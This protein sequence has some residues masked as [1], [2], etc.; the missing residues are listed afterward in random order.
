MMWRCCGRTRWTAGFHARFSATGRRYHYVILNRPIRPTY[1]RGRVSWEYRPL[2]AAA[3]Q[4][5]AQYLIGEHDFSSFR[6]AECQAKSPVREL[7]GLE[8]TRHGEFVHIRVYAN[9]FL[10][11]MVRNIAGVLMSIGAGEQQTRLGEGSAR[12]TRPHA[13]RRDRA[14]GRALSSPTSSTPSSSKSSG[15]HGI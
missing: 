10:Q 9:A 4:Q 12:S 8:V 14:A 13:G 7:R 2:D 3:M 15:F 11:H 5:G 1:L 6:A